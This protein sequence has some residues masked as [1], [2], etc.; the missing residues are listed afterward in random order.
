[1]VCT[2]VSDVAQQKARQLAA[3]RGVTLN[4]SLEDVPNPEWPPEGLDLVGAILI[5]FASPYERDNYLRR[6]E[7]DAE[8]GRPAPCPGLSSRA[9]SVWNRRAPAC[10]ESLYAEIAARAFAEPEIL[11]LEAYGAV[12]S[13]G[14]A[15]RTCRPGPILWR[16]TP[17]DGSLLELNREKGSENVLN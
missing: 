5:Q 10:R 6:H 14:T 17:A 2:D 4:L 3:D 12:L 15:H 8:V 13:E 7:A 9:A 16:G 11:Q 1:M